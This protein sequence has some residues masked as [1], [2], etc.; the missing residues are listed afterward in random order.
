M[1]NWFLY[2]KIEFYLFTYSFM[3]KYY[4]AYKTHGLTKFMIENLSH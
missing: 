2:K 1:K 4:Y 3:P